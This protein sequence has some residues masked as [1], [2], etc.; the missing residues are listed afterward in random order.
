M[1]SVLR[2]SQSNHCAY[3]TKAD[4][5]SKY[6]F[7]HLHSE[8]LLAHDGGNLALIVLYEATNGVYWD[9]DHM[10]EVPEPDQLELVQL[11]QRTR[12]TV[13]VFTAHPRLHGLSWS[14]PLSIHNMHAFKALQRQLFHRTKR[15][16]RPALTAVITRLQYRDDCQDGHHFLMS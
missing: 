12:N 13:L 1:K 11:Q 9:I 3:L 2:S 15:K 5:S 6:N 10:I 7:D 16:L 14:L 8:A 4:K